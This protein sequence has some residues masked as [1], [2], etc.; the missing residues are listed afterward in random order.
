MDFK[1]YVEIVQSV[2]YSLKEN[3]PLLLTDISKKITITAIIERHPA[4][5]ARVR[6]IL[7]PLSKQTMLVPLEL[8][9]SNCSSAVQ[10]TPLDIVML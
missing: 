10:M 9:D 6:P 7:W 5:A 4:S 8:L 3:L 1:L 2:S